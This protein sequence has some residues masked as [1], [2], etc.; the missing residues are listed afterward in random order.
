MSAILGSVR[1]I[2]HDTANALIDNQIPKKMSDL[3]TG[4]V[5]SGFDIVQ[6]V[7]TIVKDVSEQAEE[8]EP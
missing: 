5:K 4:A 1:Q 7:L 3:V 2:V 6:D 8:E